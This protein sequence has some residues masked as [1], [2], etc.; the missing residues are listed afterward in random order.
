[1]R[2]RFIFYIDTTFVEGVTKSKGQPKKSNPEASAGWK[3]TGIIVAHTF[4]RGE[5]K[6]AVVKLFNRKKKDETKPI[7]VEEFVKKKQLVK[8]VFMGEE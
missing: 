4:P 1:V 3:K 6:F 8:V 5:V 7:K 2:T